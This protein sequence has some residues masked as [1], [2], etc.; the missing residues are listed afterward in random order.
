[1][2]RTSA[3]LRMISLLMFSVAAFPARAEMS[4]VT[5]AVQALGKVRDFEQVAIS[6]DGAQ[7][8][9]VELLQDA[10]GAPSH[11]TAIYCKSRNDVAQTKRITG[12]GS[13]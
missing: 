4:D 8:A 3:A 9:W 1:M 7:V 2:N 5:A 12:G 13:G 6:P 10:S 11:N